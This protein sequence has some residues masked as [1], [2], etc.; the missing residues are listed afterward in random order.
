MQIQNSSMM[1][2]TRLAVL[3]TIITLVYAPWTL[4]TVSCYPIFIVRAATDS[5]VQGIF[6]MEFFVMDEDT[7]RLKVSPQI[8]QF[9]VTGLAMTF[10]TLLLYFV[11]G[12]FPKYKV[13]RA[14]TVRSQKRLSIIEPRRRATDEEVGSRRGF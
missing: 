8:W 7:Q 12:G 6:G 3:I 5:V 2:Q 11:M 13:R 1:L 10:L 14:A 4:I 9:F